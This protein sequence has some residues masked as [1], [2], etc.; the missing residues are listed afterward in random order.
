MYLAVDIKGLSRFMWFVL[1]WFY[2][3]IIFSCA[4]T[5]RTVKVI[6]YH[7]IITHVWPHIMVPFPSLFLDCKDNR[8]APPTHRLGPRE[9][10]YVIT[11]SRLRDIR[12]EFLYCFFDQGGDDG[13]GDYQPDIHNSVPQIHKNFNFQLPFYGFRFNYTRVR[14][15]IQQLRNVWCGSNTSIWIQERMFWIP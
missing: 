14:T 5:Q 3:I 4:G 1:C 10:A 12:S 11:E 6:N 8:F 13:N 7:C 15:F 2:V 9:N